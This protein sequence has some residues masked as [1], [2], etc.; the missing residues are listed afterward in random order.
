MA[1]YEMTIFDD[2]NNVIKAHNINEASDASIREGILIIHD[3]NG[4]YY[5]YKSW[6]RYTLTEVESD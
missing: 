1:K 5:G 6:G 4:K 2:S 3:L